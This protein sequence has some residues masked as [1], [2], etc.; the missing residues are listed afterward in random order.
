[1]AWLPVAMEIFWS[2]GVLWSDRWGRGF[3]GP[4]KMECGGSKG[5]PPTSAQEP[6]PHTSALVWQGPHRHLTGTTGE[7]I[8]LAASS[9][10]ASCR[11]RGG[12][13]AGAGIPILTNCLVGWLPKLRCEKRRRGKEVTHVLISP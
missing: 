11:G 5:V 4:A 3:T 9:P 6:S 2:L 13:A 8:N 12:R 1:M 10:G 7:K